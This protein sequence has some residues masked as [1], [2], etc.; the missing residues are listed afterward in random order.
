MWEV[1]RRDKFREDN[2]RLVGAGAGGFTGETLDAKAKE[3]RKKAEEDARRENVRKIGELEGTLEVD[4]NR[5]D[6]ATG[7]AERVEKAKIDE[8]KK[9]ETKTGLEECCDS[10]VKAL[11]RIETLLGGTIQASVNPPT[12][13]VPPTPPST[14]TPPID[15]A[16]SST[17]PTVQ[18]PPRSCDHRSGTSGIYD[19]RHLC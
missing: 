1:L 7:L 12:T 15:P 16:Q 8:D 18:S 5:V 2:K 3:V 14:V 9:S 4:Q 11:G 13:I 10:I 6:S 19:P 17:A